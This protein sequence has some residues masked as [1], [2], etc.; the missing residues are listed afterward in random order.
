[1]ITWFVMCVYECPHRALVAPAVVM[2]SPV[3]ASYER[4]KSNGY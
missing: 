3:A 1:M 4:L 2:A